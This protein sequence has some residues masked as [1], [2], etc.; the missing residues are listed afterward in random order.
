VWIDWTIAFGSL[1][2]LGVVGFTIH[3]WLGRRERIRRELEQSGRA[4]A[5]LP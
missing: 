2:L 4:G 1:L 5:G 3:W